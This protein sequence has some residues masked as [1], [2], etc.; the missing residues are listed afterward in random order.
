[1]AALSASSGYENLTTE[2]LAGQGNGGFQIA[3]RRQ[4]LTT[5]RGGYD[6]LVQVKYLP[7]PEVPHYLE[8]IVELGVLGQ[9][10]IRHLGELRVRHPDQV[11]DCR[12][13]QLLGAQ[14]EALRRFLKLLL[15][16]DGEFK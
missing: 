3:E 15:L 16:L 6:P 7:E 8:A 10:T 14:V 11:S 4:G 12:R 1:M 13:G 2:S 9:H 5:A